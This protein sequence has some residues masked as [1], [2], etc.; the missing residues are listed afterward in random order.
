MVKN[1]FTVIYLKKD[2]QVMI[3]IIVFKSRKCHNSPVNCQPLFIIQIPITPFSNFFSTACS[4][5]KISQLSLNES[6]SSNREIIIKHIQLLKCS[7]QLFYDMN[8]Y[9]L[10]PQQKYHN[11]IIMTS[12]V[13]M[14]HF[15]LY[16]DYFKTSTQVFLS[17]LLSG[18]SSRIICFDHIC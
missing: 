11:Y 16:K 5:I 6:V 13:C 10:S 15:A 14:S 18:N 8:F 3:I 17:F 4:L 2:M 7:V 1:R 9:S 12:Q